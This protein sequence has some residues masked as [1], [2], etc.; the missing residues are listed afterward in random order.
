MEPR[1]QLIIDPRTSSSVHRTPQYFQFDSMSVQCSAHQHLSMQQPMSWAI[2]ALKRYR[3]FENGAPVQVQVY[4]A[5]GGENIGDFSLTVDEWN[6]IQRLLMP[7][8]KIGFAM[9]CEFC[10]PDEKCSRCCAEAGKTWAHP[11]L[12]R[13]Q[14]AVQHLLNDPPYTIQLGETTCSGIGILPRFRAIK[15]M[16][17]NLKTSRPP[18]EKGHTNIRLPSLDTQ[19]RQ[20]KDWG[21]DVPTFWEPMGGTEDHRLCL[22]LRR[23][24]ND[25]P[26]IVK[27]ELRSRGGLCLWKRHSVAMTCRRKRLEFEPFRFKEYGRSSDFLLRIYI[28]DE[29]PIEDR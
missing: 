1:S 9:G 25:L 16:H 4:F 21:I 10:A 22:P 6:A 29:K 24:S 3:V 23:W 20:L 26:A 5:I 19:R 17:V 14:E 11:H 7:N 18:K 12:F 8:N 2:T 28:F 15:T 27:V 13:L